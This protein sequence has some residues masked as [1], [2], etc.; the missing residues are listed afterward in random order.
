MLLLTLGDWWSALSGAQQLFWGISVVFSVLFLIQFVFSLIGLDSDTDIDAD[1]D[2]DIDAGHDYHLDSDFTVFS[3]RS[4]IAFFTFFGWTGVLVLNAGGNTLTA[5]IGA[6]I[7]GL[8]AMF[9]VGYMMYQFS[10]LG[11]EGNIDINNALFNTG[12][13]YLTIPAAKAGKGKVQIKIQGALRELN[14]I[15]ENP[16]ALSTGSPIRVIEV[17]NNELLVVEPVE[18]LL[19]EGDNI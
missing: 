6:S 14:A 16:K 1:L 5:I 9:L 11:E 12:E 18:R 8:A 10:R 17:I 13:V 15:T 19:P 2:A 4:I 7:A 3:V